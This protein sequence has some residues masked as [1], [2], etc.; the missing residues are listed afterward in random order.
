MNDDNPDRKPFSVFLAEHKRGSLAN[1][2]AEK[3]QKI[4]S[5]AVE[6]QKKG[7]LTLKLEI[8]PSKDGVSVYV[9]DDIKTFIPEAERGGTVMFS[10]AKGNLYRNDPN[11]LELGKF[12]IVETK[13]EKPIVVETNTGEVVDL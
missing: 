5:A 3:M 10:D 13:D 4:V 8:S 9:T 6:H 7:S 1:E 12:H 11:Q 2:L